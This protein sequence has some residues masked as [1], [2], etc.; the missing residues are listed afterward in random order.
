MHGNIVN[1]SQIYIKRNLVM[2]NHSICTYMR[3]YATTYHLQLYF[4]IFTTTYCLL[5]FTIIFAT[6]VHY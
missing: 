6:M 2:F 4:I 3:L 5:N 1:V